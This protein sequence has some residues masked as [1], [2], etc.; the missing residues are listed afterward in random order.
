MT[1]TI[2][3]SFLATSPVRMRQDQVQLSSTPLNLLPSGI[4]WPWAMAVWEKIDGQPLPHLSQ[5]H[6]RLSFAQ[7]AVDCPCSRVHVCVTAA[8]AAA[9]AGAAVVCCTLELTV[10]GA[11]GSCTLGLTGAGSGL[12]SSAGEAIEGVA[13]G[14]RLAWSA[15]SS[16]KLGKAARVSKASATM[17]PVSV[18]VKKI[19]PIPPHRV[20]PFLPSGHDTQ[21]P[22]RWMGCTW[23]CISSEGVPGLGLLDRKDCMLVRLASLYSCVCVDIDTLREEMREGVRWAASPRDAVVSVR[24]TSI[25]AAF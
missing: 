3:A 21:S 24:N 10:A 4:P 9:E 16:L 1:V 17:T 23:V 7:I 5:H 2:T 8:G 20:C 12:L 6:V 13:S 22:S 19:H 11:V 18:S 15:G 25:S 14:I